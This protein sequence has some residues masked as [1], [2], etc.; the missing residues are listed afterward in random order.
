MPGWSFPPRAARP[1]PRVPTAPEWAGRFVET[2]TPRTASPLFRGN[3]SCWEPRWA[4]CQKSVRKS[5][6]CFSSDDLA[7]F[8]RFSCPAGQNPRYRRCS[9]CAGP[10]GHG[11]RST[12]SSRLGIGDSDSADSR[13][14]FWQTAQ[15]PPNPRVFENRGEAR[16]SSGTRPAGGARLS[17]QPF[18]IRV[19]P[20]F[21]THRGL[22]GG[23]CPFGSFRA[24]VDP[25]DSAARGA[26]PGTPHFSSQGRRAVQYSPIAPTT[27]GPA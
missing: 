13:T 6:G 2:E 14:D 25:R 4:V 18:K 27:P 3:P 15:R 11:A 16:R 1:P 8:A 23:N 22:S 9:R 24:N 20:G 10:F 19:H 12:P 26:V 21:R 7:R 5:G 17:N